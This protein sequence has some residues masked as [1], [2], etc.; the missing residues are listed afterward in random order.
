MH[1]HPAI[2]TCTHTHTGTDTRTHTHTHTH[3]H[4]A[5]HTHTHTPPPSLPHLGRIEIDD[6]LDVFEIHATRHSVLL[7]VIHALA[8]PLVPI[9]ATALALHAS[10]NGYY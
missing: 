8:L 10:I 4:T 1:P 2:R 9:P 6:R 5:T 3:T 7:L